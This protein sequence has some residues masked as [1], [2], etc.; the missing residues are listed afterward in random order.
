M[1]DIA[2]AHRA[3]L[4]RGV[5]QIQIR[6][7]HERVRHP[8]S[9]HPRDAAGGPVEVGILRVRLRL[10]VLE[11][12]LPPH[13]IRDGLLHV[14]RE[15]HLSRRKRRRRLARRRLGGQERVRYCEMADS[16]KRE[17]RD[18]VIGV[19]LGEPAL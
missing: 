9:Q 7:D 2:F 1:E 19:E 3:L 13:L 4:T 5:D 18:S 16:C 10:V 6:S 17:P 14:G 8:I 15:S 11:R 12:D